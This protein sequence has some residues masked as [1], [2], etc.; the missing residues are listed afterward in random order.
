[1]ASVAGSA[2]SFARP[3]KAT[4][5][6]SISFTSARKGNA[7][8][9]MQPV[10]MRFA[11]CCFGGPPQPEGPGLMTEVAFRRSVAGGHLPEERGRRSPSEGAWPEVTVRRSVAGGHLPEERG[12]R[13]PPGGAWP[14]VAVRRSVAGG[15]RP[16][17]RGRRSP[18]GGAKPE[19]ALRRRTQ[20]PAF[21]RLKVRGSRQARRDEPKE[22]LGGKR[23]R[24]SCE[25]TGSQSSEPCRAAQ[26]ASDTADTLSESNL[27]VCTMYLFVCTTGQD[28]SGGRWQPGGA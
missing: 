17:E 12:R 15:P 22:S 16:E 10:P 11:V 26:E 1:M 23:T 4:N 19:V 27:L 3:V 25:R 5:T 21:R 13:S 8:L 2:L 7:F 18:S 24:R 14:E 20:E 6:N 28:W 9:R